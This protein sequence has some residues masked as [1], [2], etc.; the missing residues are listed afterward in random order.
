MGEVIVM[1]ATAVGAMVAV[2]VCTQ[3]ARPTF[4]A[5]ERR[6]EKNLALNKM[7]AL[8]EV[9]EPGEEECRIFVQFMRKERSRLLMRL[10]RVVNYDKQLY[11]RRMI[12]EEDSELIGLLFNYLGLV[13][14]N[15]LLSDGSSHP[16]LEFNTYWRRIIYLIGSIDSNFDRDVTDSVYKAVAS[17]LKVHNVQVVTLS[18]I[19]QMENGY[20]LFL[21]N[22]ADY[23]KALLLYELIAK[24]LSQTLLRFKQI[25]EEGKENARRETESEAKRIQEDTRKAIRDKMNF[26]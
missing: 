19:F 22:R 6:S 20:E 7:G 1:I 24:D 10:N 15:D 3:V 21:E 5:A 8:F 25:Q 2:A 17:I 4:M 18:E 14:T 23:E 13:E 11:S 9:E 16:L 26:L 12:V